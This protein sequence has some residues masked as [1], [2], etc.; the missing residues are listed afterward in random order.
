[1]KAQDH[2]LSRQE[3]RRYGRHLVLPEVGLE[4]Q[5]K[6][7]AG[8]VLVV[9]A[10]GLGSPLSIYLAAAGVGRIGLVDFDTVE[11]SNLQRQILYTD[12]DLGHAKLDAAVRHLR[13][14][15]PNVQFV[16]HSARLSRDNAMEILRDYDLIADGS[17]NFATRYLVNDA[18]V[19]L[20][21]PNVHSSI[22]RFEGQASVFWTGHGPCYRCLFP[23]PPPPGMVESCAE[24]GVLGVLPG[25]MGSIQG[26][27]V[28]KLIL[29]IG[30]PLIGRMLLFDGLQMNVRTLK[31]RR[32]P[33]CPVCGDDP[34][35]TELLDY[36]SICGMP[37]E[38]K[39]PESNLAQSSGPHADISVDELFERRKGENPPLV[40][41]VREPQEL[42]ICML[43]GA[44]HIP[45][46]Q[47]EVRVAELDPRRETVLLCHHGIRSAHAAAYL[48]RTGFIN[49]RNLVG[50]IEA[51][52]QRIDPAMARY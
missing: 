30:S 21:K 2:G 3:M 14:I 27:E 18:C 44:V 41:D 43:E 11:I 40:L 20:K 48:R 23:D 19:F 22:L 42:E 52:A 12:E 36:D 32:D 7:K 1:M 39:E 45:L 34:R 38:A 51:W 47:L 26:M 9:G 28:I 10:G 8:S 13:G 49:A 24:G 6:L 33:Q 17:D 50:G 25:I 35:I 29:G 16:K 31:L 15:N 46:G 37:A 4:G 5:N